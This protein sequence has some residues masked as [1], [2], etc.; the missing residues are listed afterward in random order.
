LTPLGLQDI[1]IRQELE[2]RRQA[3]SETLE[4]RFE[5]LE[6]LEDRVFH[7]LSFESAAGMTAARQSI[8]KNISPGHSLVGWME[9]AEREAQPTREESQEQAA[10][11]SKPA[12][13]GGVLEWR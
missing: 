10:G 7:V 2:A 3:E 5:M 6:I 13:S 4:D 1:N 11:Q 12:Q 8:E 9:G